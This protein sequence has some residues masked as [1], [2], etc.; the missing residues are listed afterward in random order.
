MQAPTP[1]LIQEY[2]DYERRIGVERIRIGCCLAM[3]M[4]PLGSIVDLFLYPKRDLGV[5]F[6]IRVMG[7]LAMLPL[8]LVVNTSW[9]SRFHRLL[10]VILAIIPAGTMVVLIFKIGTAASPYYAGLNLVLLAVGFVLQWTFWQSMSAVGAVLLMYAVL[11]VY[12]GFQSGDGGQFFSNFYFL[13]LTGV[14]VVVG[15]TW[16]S[17]LRWREFQLR[18]EVDAS[19]RALEISNQRLL[20]LD[21]L[22]GRFFANISHELRTPLTLLLVP[23]E[24]LSAQPEFKADP[25]V[26]EL[27]DTMHANGMRLLKLINDLLDLVRLDAGKMSLKLVSIDV[28]R[29]FPGLLQ[30]VRGVALD[31]SITLVN[32]LDPAMEFVDGDPDRLEKVFLNLLFNAVKF[33]P[34]GGKIELAGH[35]EDDQAIFEV[36]DTGVGIPKE[37][38]GYVFERFWQ[39]DSSPQRKYQGAGIGLALVRELV[40]AHGGEVNAR[41]APGQGT[42]MTVRLPLRNSAPVQSPR[43]GG[44]APIPAPPVTD[45]VQF[46]NDVA[47]NAIT[48]TNAGVVESLYRRAELFPGIASLRESLRPTTTFGGRRRPKVLVA[49]DEPDMLRFLRMQLAEDYEVIE[50]VDGEQALALA[51]QYQPEA[52]VCDMMMPE[53]DGVQV[54]QA[55]RAESLTRSIPFLMLTARADDETKVNALTAGSNDFLTKPF[56][57]AELRL[58]LK[59]LVDASDLQRAV[60]WQNR[61]LEAALEQVKDSETQLVQSEK[62]ASLGRLAAGIIH[63]INNPLNYARTALYVLKQKGPE[64]PESSRADFADSV[65]DIE[66]GL[67]RVTTIV[68]DLRGFTHPQGG[69]VGDVEV[70]AVVARTLRMFSSELDGSVKVV[71]DLPEDLAVVAEPN[72]LVQVLIN[73]VQNAIDAT[74]AKKAEGHCPEIRIYSLVDENVVRVIVRDN[75]SGISKKNLDKI[76]EPFFTTKDVGSG[77]GLGLSICYR[78]MNEFGGRISVDSEEGSYAEFALE[79]PRPA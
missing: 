55:L 35:V 60:L 69:P 13:A 37:Q 48:E 59:N 16:T 24:R 58:R 29:F 21:Q 44:V 62:L 61:K 40:Q 25:A 67:K 72:R 56:S 33:T 20:E 34:A 78:L 32:R 50:A 79:F 6:F 36:I 28:H 71:V 19:R 42:A 76:F 27:L 68:S 14:I 49:D 10:G 73:L 41:S 31:K 5:Y 65:S 11:G 74:K 77:T 64:L 39:G 4:L 26:R 3:G 12:P 8:L 75:G 30:S 53:K 15:N 70:G 45:S 57:S 1:E 46:A 23:L 2:S 17:R 66:D 18:T 22:K 52:I 51:R 63:E 47:V 9:G 7:S 38:L 43:V 54:C